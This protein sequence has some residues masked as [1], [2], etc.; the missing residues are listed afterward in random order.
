[1]HTKVLDLNGFTL[2][3]KAAFTDLIREFDG[4]CVPD[5]EFEFC[6][7]RMKD[8]LLDLK[9]ALVDDWS[10][11]R[12]DSAIRRF[13]KLNRIFS[14]NIPKI[15]LLWAAS[16]SGYNYDKLV[17]PD[18][19]NITKKYIDSLVNS[20][21]QSLWPFAFHDIDSLSC[22]YRRGLLRLGFKKYSFFERY[23]ASGD[24]FL[25]KTRDYVDQLLSY[26][27]Q[28]DQHTTVMHNGFEPFR[29]HDVKTFCHDGK[30]IVITRDPRD[31]YIA[32][33]AVEFSASADVDRFIYQYNMQRKVFEERPECQHVMSVGFEDLVLNYEATVNR[34]LTFLEQDE[35]VH[36]RKKFYFDPAASI[37]GVGMWKKH[38]HQDNINKIYKELPE[39][40]VELPAL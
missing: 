39:Y 25:E 13:S 38:E 4:F 7:F 19:F 32:G 2:S 11:V 34:I 12:S 3:G 16:P 20:S 28:E 8:G 14:S 1:M 22:L 24:Q 21:Y 26:N 17:H 18:F 31:V 6:L 40:C 37:R 36:S 33:L 30:S 15:S 27:L 23:V 10:P 29:A 5:K 9:Y 35:K